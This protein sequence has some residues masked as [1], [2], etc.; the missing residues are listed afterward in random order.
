MCEDLSITV[1]AIV[2]E[3]READFSIEKYVGENTSKQVLTKISQ[4]FGHI[5]SSLMFDR[6]LIR[7]SRYFCKLTK[8]DWSYIVKNVTVDKNFFYY[9]ISFFFLKYTDRDRAFLEDIGIELDRVFGK[10]NVPVV[11]LN[12]ENS[13]R[14][15]ESC[16][17]S[18]GISE[19]A[20]LEVRSYGCKD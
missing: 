1:A 10:G 3:S 2:R 18:H 13:R 12:D 11:N 20:V 6:V 5:S 4:I 14:Y 15:I 17:N 16:F 7:S 8:K 9:N 19:K